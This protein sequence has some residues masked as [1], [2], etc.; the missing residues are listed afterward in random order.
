MKTNAHRNYD[1]G[2]TQITEN[3]RVSSTAIFYEAWFGNYFQY[4][5]FVFSED[6][7]IKSRQIIHGSNVGKSE[8]L[9]NKTRKIH[10]YI[11]R[12]LQRKFL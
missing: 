8:S 10:D 12:N 5:T 1:L 4:E 7:K 11:S 3:I 6:P 2:K 9:E